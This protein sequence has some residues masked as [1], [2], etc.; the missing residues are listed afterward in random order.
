M[1]RERMHAAL[2]ALQESIF[3]DVPRDRLPEELKRIL[4]S[5]SPEGPEGIGSICAHGVRA[6]GARSWS[7]K[8]DWTMTGVIL[9]VIDMRMLYSI[10]NPCRGLWKEI[11]FEAN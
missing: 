9:D 8:P 1:R 5:H 4:S 2:A 6:P 10:G 11:A 7:S 3:E